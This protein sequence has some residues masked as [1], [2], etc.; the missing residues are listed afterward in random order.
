MTLE[1]LK[2]DYDLKKGWYD[3]ELKVNA[4]S[5]TAVA[6]LTNTAGTSG[7]GTVKA[8]WS[9]IYNNLAWWEQ[10]LANSNTALA[11]KKA[12]MD[13]AKAEYDAAKKA[14]D[15][16]RQATMNLQASNPQLWAQ[17]QL[18]KAEAA[19]SSAKTQG[20]TKYL[21]WGAVALVIIGIVV[22]IIRKKVAA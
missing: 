10:Q 12:A 13:A 14:A 5:K 7:L 22:I 19:I 3:E 15:A 17:M 9:G 11:N 1:D 18:A 20:T 21:I 16:E 4:E 2:A 8:S 6:K